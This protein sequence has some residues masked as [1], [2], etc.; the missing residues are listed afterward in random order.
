MLGFC[1]DKKHEELAVKAVKA[2]IG[3]QNTKFEHTLLPFATGSDALD[4]ILRDSDQTVPMP[5]VRDDDVAYLHHTSG[6]SSGT[7]KPIPQ[8]HHGAVGVLPAF[9]GRSK[10]TLTTTP[11]YHGGPA[12][13]FRAWTS[14]AMICLFP[15][16]AA[17]ITPSNISKC[18][19]AAATAAELTPCPPI[20]YFTTV[21]YILQTMAEDAES[22]KWLGKMDLVS[23]GGAALPSEVGDKLV[24]EGINLV[25]RFGS[26]ECGFLLSSH[27]D[28]END[29]QWQYLR[30]NGEV[31][32]LDFEARE[33]D[34]F[35]LVIK[36]DWPHMAKRN[37]NDGSYATS[38][39]FAK[40][41]SIPNAWRYH[42]RAD[43]QLT[44]ITGKKFDPA[45]LEGA[46]V[47]ASRLVSDVLVFGNGRPYPGALI[48]RSKDTQ[49]MTDQ[50]VLHEIAPIVEKL[51]HES[52]G[53]AKILRNMLI[54]MPHDETSLEKSSKGSV[55]R[56]KAEERYSGEIS[57][58]Y[59]SIVKETSHDLSDDQ[60]QAAIFDLVNSIVGSEEAKYLRPDAD[61]FSNGVDSVACVQIRHGLSRMLPRNAKALPL[62]V[63]EDSMTVSKLADLIIRIRHGDDTKP[64]VD[65]RDDI[66]KLVKQFAQV[67]AGQEM[68]GSTIGAAS[69]VTETTA[70]LTVLITGPTGSLGTHVLSELLQRPEVTK[71]YLLIRGT[72]PQA[73]RERV[74]KALSSRLVPVPQDFDSKVTVLQC[75]LSEPK[76]GLSDQEYCKLQ[77]SVDLILHLAWSVNFLLTLG[78]FTPHFAGIQNLLNL[79]LSSTNPVVPRIVFCSSVASVSAFR[80]VDSSSN[81]AVPEN[82]INSTTV[83]GST[84]YAHSKLT[85]E[86]ILAHSATLNARL[87]GRITVVR[88]GQ[89]SADSKHGVWN[90]SEAYPQI[91]ASSKFT[92]GAIPDLGDEERLT[93]LPVDVAAKSFVEASLESESVMANVPTEHVKH[94]FGQRPDAKAKMVVMTDEK[95]LDIN[96]AAVRVVHLT[97][98]DTRF[99]FTDFVRR[100]QQLLQSQGQHLQHET[101]TD[102]ETS[103][104]PTPQN[105]R[106]VSVKDWLESLEALQTRE[107]HS[108][109]QSLLRL[110]PFWK[111]AYMNRQPSESSSS[112]LTPSDRNAK[113]VV[114]FTPDLT[115]DMHNSLIT[116]P[117]LTYWLGRST[118]EAAKSRSKPKSK[119]DLAAKGIHSAILNGTIHDSEGGDVNFGLEVSESEVDLDLT[120]ENEDEANE[121]EVAELLNKAYVLKIWRWVM[122]N[123]P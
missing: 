41:S 119:P 65:S 16:Q 116:M 87:H 22:L 94:K 102:K 49:S 110:L 33:G 100:L 5:H 92:D 3:S 27:R 72:T 6:T 45:L 67:Y 73:A 36:P 82:V 74:L 60:I 113:S 75:K 20:K 117:S 106:I 111:Q 118:L 71:I 105:I 47:A 76:L 91:L 61:L 19:T 14:N 80:A 58:A 38:D 43:S 37:R 12:D 101:G 39:L 112:Y 30:L 4:V 10:A 78:S 13:I 15:G 32:Q 104:R 121:V 68:N 2:K 51:N 46:I 1:A 23:V 99:G 66:P 64:P 115:F 83:S 48:F 8:T 7:P 56:N 108:E 89:L 63:V 34:L 103:D 62:N 95:D 107:Q 84:G 81:C 44:L 25:S 35:E 24:L 120:K 42:S 17:P 77:N 26:A 123:V 96:K 11:L 122:E 79:S 28:Y 109:A 88:V 59:D 53:H 21:P 40:H 18:F 90:K 57:K 55:L 114:P 69:S 54:L 29:K 93:W 9:D 70:K 50:D 85:A 86:L 97:N 31:T 52:Q 98:P